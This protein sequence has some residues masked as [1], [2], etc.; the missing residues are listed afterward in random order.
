MRSIRAAVRDCGFF[1]ARTSRRTSPLSERRNGI[2]S[3]RTEI[4]DRSIVSP[5]RQCLTA[6][7]C[8]CNTIRRGRTPDLHARSARRY[9]I[10]ATILSMSSI[11][12]DHPYPKFL[13]VEP[14]Q[15]PFWRPSEKTDM[16]GRLLQV[17]NRIAE[18]SQLVFPPRF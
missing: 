3:E 16:L 12:M 7:W 1:R 6:W 14:I 2:S 17:M 11:D 8:P 5:G 10:S 18:Y 4:Q 13:S 9:S 15:R